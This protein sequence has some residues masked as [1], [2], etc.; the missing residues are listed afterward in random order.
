MKRIIL[1]GLIIFLQIGIVWADE[2]SFIPTGWGIEKPFI[3]PV[4]WG[5][6]APLP[7]NFMTYHSFIEVYNEFFWFIGIP[8]FSWDI[9]IIRGKNGQ[10]IFR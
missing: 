4:G 1:I 7:S 8:G 10:N 6:E 5:I 3:P 2:P 9:P